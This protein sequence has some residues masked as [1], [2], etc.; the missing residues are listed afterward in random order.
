MYIM[1]I[2]QYNVQFVAAYLSQFGYNHHNNKTLFIK[3][4][5][6][7]LRKGDNSHRKKQNIHIIQKSK[8]IFIWPLVRGILVGSKQ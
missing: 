3:Y 5:H 7:K 2:T 8:D 4:K 6:H 1:Q